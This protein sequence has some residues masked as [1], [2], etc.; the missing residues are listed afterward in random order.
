MLV[1]A[2]DEQRERLHPLFWMHAEQREARAAFGP[3][4]IFA[5]PGLKRVRTGDTLCAP[6]AL[7]QLEPPVFPVPV[8]RRSVEPREPSGRA[9]LAA[10]LEV[11]AREDPTLSVAPDEDTGGYVLAGM[12]ELHLQVA[13][14]RLER[15]FHLAVRLGEPRVSLAEAAVAAA[16]GSGRAEIPG[17]APV[18]VEVLAR[19]EPQEGEAA[20]LALS[21]DLDPLPEAVRRELLDPR[22]AASLSGPQ[23]YPL[24]RTRVTLESV[25][26]HPAQR[27]AAPELVLGALYGAVEQAMNLV[28]AVLEPVM[29]LKV[30]VPEAFLAPILADLQQRQAEIRDV[31][32]EG[33][34]RRIEAR[35]A[36]S[37]LLAYS[38]AIRSLSQGKAAFD[39]VP[40]GLAPVGR[41]PFS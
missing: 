15:E 7:L 35:V 29:D 38:T 2:R 36:L 9:R 26:V 40:A 24:R 17:E 20:T 23:G 21:R 14:H 19:V 34:L 5:V 33:E 6:G 1:N 30:E 32:A 8:L 31:V 22:T 18:R 37:R 25:Q 4:G 39:L 11:L 41:A 12:G 3:G 10:A 13:G 27:G 28:G 16:Q